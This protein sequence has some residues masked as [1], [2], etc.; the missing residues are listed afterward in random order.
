MKII[1]TGNSGFIAK[2]F[3]TNLSK[4]NIVYS[5]T[6]KKKLAN[7]KDNII[8]LNLSNKNEVIK[9]IKSKKINNIF[10]P[11]V[12]IH[13]SS[14]T[15]NKKR[16][17]DINILDNN[18]EITKN[19]IL[20]CKKLKPYLF[21]NFSSTSVYPQNSGEYNENSL[22]KPEL[23]N[24]CLYGLSKYNS[25]VLFSY[26][27]NLYKIK[28]LNLRISQV[29]GENMNSN[30]ILPTLIKE[31][32]KKNTI[33]LYGQ[34]KRTSNFIEIE[35]LYSLV[36]FLIKNKVTGLYNIGDK[37]YSYMNLAKKIKSKYG[38]INTKII[39]LKNGISS[40]FKLNLNKLKN[41]IKLYE[42]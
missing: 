2:Y 11:D 34:G 36:F 38:N 31:I 37:N 20:I 42:K 12:V 6:S 22:T 7:K 14:I 29:L 40:K 17:M 13:L 15:M 35:K 24:D 27:F 4:K 1:I 28:L 10:K 18:N 21:V 16:T 26:F 19:I 9:F 39:L 30:R 5:I 41:K 32:N 23:N 25:E 8:Y 3:Y 33:T